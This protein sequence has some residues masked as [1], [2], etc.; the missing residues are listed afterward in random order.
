VCATGQQARSGRSLCLVDGGDLPFAG[1]SARI[2]EVISFEST[3]AN[4][5]LRQPVGLALVALARLQSCCC[6]AWKKRWVMSPVPRPGLSTG[7]PR[8]TS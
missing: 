5:S 4:K 2:A 1:R 3:K 6:A 8:T 7:E